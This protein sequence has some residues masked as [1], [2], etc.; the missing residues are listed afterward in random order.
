MQN[1]NQ[2]I[3]NI[4]EDE[5]D[6]RELFLTLWKKKFFIIIFTGLVTILAI[7]YS[8]MKTPIYEAKAVVEIGSYKHNNK[9]ELLADV[10]KLSQTLNVLYIDILKNQKERTSWIDKI[11]VL[12]KQ[13]NFIE[14]H[15]LG[16]SNEKAKEELQQIITYMKSEH[17]KIINEILNQKDIEIKNIDRNIELLKSNNLITIA[18]DIHYVQK[19]KIPSIAEK[20]LT[21]K[22]KLKNIE[23]QIKI[24]QINILKTQKKDPT[25]TA[26]NV[27]EKRSLESELSSLK[28]DIIDLLE[29]KEVLVSQTLPRLLRAKAKIIEVDLKKLFEQKNI[30]EQSLLPHNYKNTAIVG[31]IMTNDYSIKP[32]KKLIVVVAFVTGFIFS[33]FIVFFMEFI[34]GFRTEESDK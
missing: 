12:K 23:E 24:T 10:N 4:Q 18:E 17:S 34:A 15:S 22:Q 26:L 20:I 29:K 27:M 16:L 8:L 6:L 3:N 19:I 11:A 28:I 7:I 21:Q 2:Q 31:N 1:T 9:V 25:L 33:I 30:L 32:K 5:I 13:K 14:I